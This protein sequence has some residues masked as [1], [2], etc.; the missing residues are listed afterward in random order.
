M[1]ERVAD[2][3]SKTVFLGLAPATGRRSLANG[4]ASPESTPVASLGSTPV[5]PT[6]VAPHGSAPVAP[7]RSGRSVMKPGFEISGLPRFSESL[8]TRLS[9]WRSP[10]RHFALGGDCAHDI[11]GQDAPIAPP[12]ASAS[13]SSLH[14]EFFTANSDQETR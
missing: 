6:R 9:N 8:C 4:S 5:T 11:L 7:T 13:L 2:A 3:D 12:S 1:Y 10:L 14:A